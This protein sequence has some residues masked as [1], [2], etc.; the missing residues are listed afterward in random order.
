MR[1]YFMEELPRHCEID[2][3][4]GKAIRRDLHGNTHYRNKQALWLLF[5]VIIISLASI[6]ST[7][8]WQGVYS[9]IGSIYL[10]LLIMTILGFIIY[11]IIAYIGKL[12]LEKDVIKVLMKHGIC[13]K[14]GYRCGNR[15]RYNEKCSE[16]GFRIFL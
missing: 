13:P 9:I 7:A 2:E 3:D 6:S 16:C 11:L 5:A 8:I 4:C 15:S 12:L 1:W 10:S 14:C